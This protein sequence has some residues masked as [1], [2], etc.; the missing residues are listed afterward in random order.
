[1]FRPQRAWITREGSDSKHHWLQLVPG[2]VAAEPQV[3]ES[4]QMFLDTGRVMRTS[5]V[6]HVER[7]AEEIV[8]DTANSRYRLKLA[9]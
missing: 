5:R 9:S 4:L 6:T 1:M 2:M 7:T 8:V 3:G